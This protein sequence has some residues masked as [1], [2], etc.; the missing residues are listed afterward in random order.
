M[1]MYNLL[2][3][4]RKNY[5]KTTDSLQ[6]YS[7]DEPSDSFSSNFK[8][9]KYKTSITGKTYNLCVVEAG[10]DGNKVGKNEA[11]VVMRSQTCYEISNSPNFVFDI[12]NLKGIKIITRLRLG[13]SHLREQIDTLFSRQIKSFM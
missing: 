7:R 10:Y 13:L 4:S 6:N 8:S 1:P 5:K 11:E 12:R 9:L 3:Y 2:E